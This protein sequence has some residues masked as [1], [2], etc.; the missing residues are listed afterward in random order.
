MYKV[1]NNFP[2][3]TIKVVILSYQIKNVNNKIWQSILVSVLTV[4]GACQNKATHREDETTGEPLKGLLLKNTG[5]CTLSAI[6][7][8]RTASQALKTGRQQVESLL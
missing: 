1:C 8:H 4:K 7:S 2:F 5:N 3:I 6:T